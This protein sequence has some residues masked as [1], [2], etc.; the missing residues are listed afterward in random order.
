MTWSVLRHFGWSIGT[1]RQVLLIYYYFKR[2]FL[3][4]F[5]FISWYTLLH[6]VLCSAS[7]LPHGLFPF[8]YLPLQN[9]YNLVLFTCCNKQSFHLSSIVWFKSSP[10]ES[11]Y[12]VLALSSANRRELLRTS[13]SPPKTIVFYRPSSPLSSSVIAYIVVIVPNHIASHISS[14]HH[15]RYLRP[16]SN[17]FK[18]LRNTSYHFAPYHT[19]SYQIAYL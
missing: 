1:I 18:P 8:S 11:K 15:S 6:T 14:P 5:S 13:S 10:L 3:H 7:C 4:H 12:F 16:S 9:I 19:S 2:F 17:I